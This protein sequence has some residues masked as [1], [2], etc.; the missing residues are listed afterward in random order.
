M[1]QWTPELEQSFQ[2]IVTY[3]NKTKIESLF[4]PRDSE[5]NVTLKFISELFK[6]IG[7]SANHYDAESKM[8]R[9]AGKTRGKY[10]ASDVVYFSTAER[11]ERGPST[12]L[13]VVEAKAPNVTDF[14]EHMLQAKRYTGFFRPVLTV[15]T[16]GLRIL[17]LRLHEN[18]ASE[19]LFDEPVT[20]LRTPDILRKLIGLLHLSVLAP[21]KAD[22]PDTETGVNTTNF[23]I[24]MELL[25]RVQKDPRI[26]GILLHEEFQPGTEEI[27][28]WLSVRRPKVSIDCSLPINLRSGSCDVSFSSVL[29]QDLSVHLDDEHILGGL[30]LGLGTS[31]DSGAR[32][33]LGGPY[34]GRYITQLGG[35]AIQLSELEA[36]DLCTCVDEVACRYQRALE[37]VEARLEAKRFP[38]VRTQLV[39]G[40]ALF[41]I[42]RSLWNLLLQFIEQS[43]MVGGIGGYIVRRDMPG[44][45]LIVEG[46]ANFR[47]RQMKLPLG[48][49]ADID[50][51]QLIYE[52]PD[53]HLLP[54]FTSPD[55]EME[56][57]EAVKKAGLLTAMEAEKWLREELIPMTVEWGKASEFSHSV[58]IEADCSR[59]ADVR[60]AP[61][62]IQDP[63]DLRTYVRDIQE[64]LGTLGPRPIEASRLRAYYS[65]ILAL[66]TCAHPPSSQMGY[67]WSNLF[68][69]NNDNRHA[70]DK[71]TKEGDDSSRYSI[72][73]AE[74]RSHVNR[75]AQVPYESS[76]TAEL[77]SRFFYALVEHSNF[78]RCPL[79]LQQVRDALDVLWD[80][81]QFDMRYVLPA[82][83]VGG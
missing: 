4:E 36:Q 8:P 83:G 52:V 2:D 71:A 25:A 79:E 42:K 56:W 82:Q 75:I 65:S 6:R 14:T 48:L 12:C 49:E 62:Q 24:V 27:G 5:N 68:D 67:L 76:G 53:R 10:P 55:D 29:L 13:L 58:D 15:L 38:V 32:D 31:P 39:K 45:R 18:G 19:T 35:T 22:I 47:I 34:G 30:V 21:M 11:K 23:G 33:F 1:V 16:N 63:R 46:K 54:P 60:P 81:S 77:L 20:N 69:P 61:S 57:Y 80:S 64:W 51:L 59:L 78:D 41:R 66:A 3:L 17:V 40:F 50:D 26:A 9:A 37:S 73:L 44:T 28:G 72:V 74:L 70:Y 7:Y 43:E